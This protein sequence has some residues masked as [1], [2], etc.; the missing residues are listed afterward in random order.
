MK[1]TQFQT[2]LF[3]TTSNIY[4]D[5]KPTQSDY[6][7]RELITA[8]LLKLSKLNLHLT[9]P[10]ILFSAN[11]DFLAIA[12][13]QIPTV[14][15]SA[16]VGAY[17]LRDSFASTTKLETYTLEE[18][19]VILAQYAVTY[20]WQDLYAAN[21]PETAVKVLANY[22][23]DYDFTTAVK[24]PSTTKEVTLLNTADAV[25]YL[26][27]ILSSPVPLRLQ[28]K[29]LLKAAPEH[30]IKLASTDFKVQATEAFYMNLMHNLGNTPHIKSP[31][32]LM[33]LI[34][35]NFQQ[36]D[37][38]IDYSGQ[39]TNSMLKSFKFHLPTRMKKV[40]LQYFNDC[41]NTDYIV[42][43]LLTN[44]QFWKRCLHHCHWTSASR[45]LKRYP[46][47][48]VLTDKLYSNDRSWTFNSRYSAAMQAG[49]FAKAVEILQERPGLVLRNL[50]NLLKYPK[51]TPLASK[52]TPN[53]T[54][55]LLDKT[56]YAKS[57]IT[58]FL[59][60]DFS[61][62]L[63]KTTPAI[64]T[65]WQLIEEIKN[66]V[67][68]SPITTRE[69][70]GVT[71]RYTTPIPAIDTTMAK[72]AL[73]TLKSYIKSV[74]KEQNKSL[75]KVYIDPS[76]A[77]IAIQYSGAES[78]DNQVS[79]NFLPPGSSITIPVDTDFIRL[80]V[81]WR[82][83]GNGSCDIDLNTSL[84]RGEQVYQCYYGAPQLQVGNKATGKPQ[85]LAVSSGDI[86]S[87]ST[88]TY[89]AEF[90]DIDYKLAQSAE[91]DTIINSLTMYSGATLD[92]YDTHLF[93]DF[94]PRSKRVM[95]SNSLTIDLARQAYAIKLNDP[96]KA[97]VGSYIDVKAGKCKFITKPISDNSSLHNTVISSFDN[98]KHLL[99]NLPQR[100]SVDYVLRKSIKKSQITTNKM[101]A[102]TVISADNNGTLN[103]LTNGEQLAKIIF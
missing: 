61:D 33:R 60:Y 16:Q 79:G 95:A 78:T 43:Q 48:K 1:A 20:G 67:H 58:A 10:E 56:K 17:K 91:I 18:T 35:T 82:D 88:T 25:V 94:I 63:T 81:V 96:A 22:A 31:T 34:L 87:C 53:T 38:A 86:T 68:Q 65:A 46:N 70:Q 52:T 5:S 77:D 27:S 21:F 76:L 11:R 80:G 47:L 90:I 7:T 101:S 19:A 55:L 83:A 14:A 42:E 98:T 24:L 2:L 72:S 30:I 92:K 69:V 71:V 32:M 89:S 23:N 93:I 6:T 50:V 64:K 54:D 97:Y 9:N 40:I 36:G 74:K 57:D 26:Q 4:I 15:N 100:L 84:L 49:D 29:Q 103:V 99:A 44:E 45:E 102:D 3:G 12:L 51:G 75:G 62:F 73:K 37:N 85:L 41:E 39:I 66:P 13:E 8:V 28:Q 59:K